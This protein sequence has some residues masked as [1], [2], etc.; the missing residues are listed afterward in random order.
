MIINRH[1]K[2]ARFVSYQASNMKLP[3][4]TPHIKLEE[5][6]KRSTP[7]RASTHNLGIKPALKKKPTWLVRREV[8]KEMG[9]HQGEKEYSPRRPDDSDSDDEGKKHRNQFAFLHARGK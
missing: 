5:K 8:D 2:E 1:S 7:A 6:K 3:Q 4:R 9:E